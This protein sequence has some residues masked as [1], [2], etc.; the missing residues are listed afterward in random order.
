MASD[1][2]RRTGGICCGD[3]VVMRSL[4]TLSWALINLPISF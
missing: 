3:E 2:S 1:A 4:L